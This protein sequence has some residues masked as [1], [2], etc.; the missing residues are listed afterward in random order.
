MT[1]KVIGPRGEPLT[2]ISLTQ[3]NSQLNPRNI[4]TNSILLTIFLMKETYVCIKELHRN[5]QLVKI[6]RTSISWSPNSYI[7]TPQGSGNITKTWLN[8]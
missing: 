1:D 8:F 7:Y 3:D 6:Q 4:F 5:S 2:A